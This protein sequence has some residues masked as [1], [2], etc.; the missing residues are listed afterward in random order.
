MPR[1]KKTEAEESAVPAVTEAAEENAPAETREALPSKARRTRTVRPLQTQVLTIEQ[2]TEA[3]LPQEQEDILWHELT[4]AY[5]TH[6]I[7][8][9]VVGG[10]ER[11]AGGGLAVIYYKDA[12]VAIPL[13]E[14]LID[15]QDEGTPYAGQSQRLERLVN[16]MMNC[17]V[18]FVIRGLDPVSRSVVASRKD[19]MLRKQ[20]TFYLTPGADG[21][22]Q[23]HEGRIVQA[24]VVAVSEKTIRIEV[25]G[26]ECIVLARDL[27][28]SW[29]CDAHDLYHVGDVILVR[30][31]AVDATDPRHIR[32]A[33]D[34]RSITEN[35]AADKLAQ[36]REQSRYAGTVTEVRKGILYIRLYNGVN[37]IA[38]NCLDARMPAKKDQV[39][40]VITHINREQNVAV[41]IITR[42]IRQ[43]L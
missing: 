8:A 42:I 35:T 4:N 37:A 32:I 5:M 28:W 38:H 23:I 15:I 10:V 30:V 11:S 6:R 1:K 43:N 9:G 16:S 21:K 27:S 13:A 18:D 7:L 19:A 12:R 41:G 20:H 24:R 3:E 36:C 29:I 2:H 39:S 14:M 25:F 34:P 26:V 31:S 17:E 22:P 33:A 40:F